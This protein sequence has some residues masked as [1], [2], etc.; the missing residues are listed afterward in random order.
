[1]PTPS[2]KAIVLLVAAARLAC[3]Q[4][5][6]L[7]EGRAFTPHTHIPSAGD[8]NLDALLASPLNAEFKQI[9]V[10]RSLLLWDCGSGSTWCGDARFSFTS[11]FPKAATLGYPDA[12]RFLKS[13]YDATKKA[14]RAYGAFPRLL[15]PWK[16]DLD[17]KAMPFRL[18]AI[19]NR[20]DLAQ[21]NDKDKG[22][23][24]R[25]E[26]AEVRFVYGPV[27][28]AQGASPPGFE[29][30]VEFVLPPSGWAEFRK[31]AEA[32]RS[33][34]DNGGAPFADRLMSVLKASN[35]DKSQGA[36]MRLN[37]EQ[38]GAQWLLAQWDFQTRLDQ[39]RDGEVKPSA[40]TD[41]ISAAYW[42]SKPGSREYDEYIKLWPLIDYDV[43]KEGIRVPSAM[44][45]NSSIA[46]HSD[47]PAMPTPMNRCVITPAIRDTLALQRCSGCHGSESGTANKHI[48]NRLANASSALSPF[49]TGGNLRP[50]IEDLYRVLP[51]AVFATQV[52][53]Q[54]FAGLPPAPTVCNQQTTYCE[55]RYYNDL[56]RRSLFLASL[57][58]AADRPESGTLLQLR[59]FRT[60]FP[61]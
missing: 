9:D 39:A 16:G 26:N 38:S 23:D 10:T 22:K 42:N 30:I 40:L 17:G 20:M 4:T 44:L 51:N 13:W 49:L 35:F 21:W 61:D 60:D 25:W 59:A 46:Y 1:M 27:L 47:D 7:L 2:C 32:W 28:N 56:A 8:P 45:A 36:R 58:A 37:Y 14:D 31:L 5:F 33:L 53:F 12:K 15:G 52:C 57:L 3:G 50:L 48:S 29:L 55:M 18:L 43:P 11:I 6:G 24:G 41:E 19:V 34:S 54:T